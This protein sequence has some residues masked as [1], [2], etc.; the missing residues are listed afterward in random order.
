MTVVRIPPTLRN[1]VVEYLADVVPDRLDLAHAADL[2]A[3]RRG[4]AD[5]DHACT[6]P[7]QNST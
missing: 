4:D 6:G 3:Q 5:G 1:E 2:A 7:W